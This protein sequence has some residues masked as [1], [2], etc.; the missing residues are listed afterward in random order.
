[1]KNTV[2]LGATIAGILLAGP[3]WADGSGNVRGDLY[4]LGDHIDGVWYRDGANAPWNI[5]DGAQNDGVAKCKAMV[6][7]AMK[8]GAKDSDKVSLGNDGPDWI[9][10]EQPFGDMKVVCDRIQRM[11]NVKVWE[12][13]AIF[14]M[15]ELGKQGGGDIKFSQNCLSLYDDMLKKGVAADSKV[16]A[17]KVNDASGTAIDWKGTVKEVRVKYCDAGYKKAKEEQEKRDAPYKKVMKG[18]KL[19]TAL[20]YRGVF[21]AGGAV[22]ED[23]AVMAKANVWFIDTE[24]QE[25]CANFTQRHVIHRFEFAG[26]KLAKST[27]IETCGVPRANNFQ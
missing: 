9:K 20:T 13:W 5:A 25:L 1:M 14:A 22:T 23:P 7:K 27:N 21:L 26:D 18:Q 8:D 12:K 19:E 17:R 6:D 24:P 10:G 15:Q 4:S 2:V 11:V 3:A 16:V